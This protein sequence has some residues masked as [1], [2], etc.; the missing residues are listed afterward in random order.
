MRRRSP[1][2]KLDMKS[3]VEHYN[4]KK[5][6]IKNRLKDFEDN[7]KKDDKHVFSE[8]CFCILTPQAEAIECDKAI[9]NLKKTR[10]L[11]KGHPK[12]ISPH[13]KS[14]RFLNKKAE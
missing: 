14:A 9:R 7:F 13:L 12:A 11:Y 1:T 6:E 5:E 4:K 2:W 8:L 10:L 3:L